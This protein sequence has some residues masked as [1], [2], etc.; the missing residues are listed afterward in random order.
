MNPTHHP[1]ED[2]WLDYAAGQIDSATRTLLDAHLAFCEACRSS[3]SRAS[4]A[5]ARML[6]EARLDP[7]PQGLLAGIL[8]R[9]KTPEA[10]RVNGVALPLPKFI[11]PLL[12]DLS[13]ASWHGAFTPG[14]R[15]LQVLQ[16]EGP[17]LFLL[18]VEA[19]RSFPRHGHS[20]LERSLVLTGG[21]RD[22]QGIMEAGDFEEAT[23]HHVHTPV[24]LED[25]DCWLLASLDGDIR[26]KGWR[27]VL[28]RLAGH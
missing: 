26:F 23:A 5:G 3:A 2:H 12:P 25:E 28:Q 6:A 18:H 21:L 11:W 24:A 13:K 27:G 15:F 22:E 9:L 7:A 14:F 4:E 8:A 17:C 20:G 19:G 16:D 1:S 10:P